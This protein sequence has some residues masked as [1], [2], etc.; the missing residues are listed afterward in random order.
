MVIYKQNPYICDMKRLLL[1]TGFLIGILLFFSDKRAEDRRADGYAA[2]ETV[3][4][5]KSQAADMQHRIVALGKDLQETQATA[6]RRAF[7]T[8]P[9]TFN[10]R[11]AQTV[12]KLLQAFRLRNEDVHYKTSENLSVCQTLHISTLFCRMASHVYALRKLVI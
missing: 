8:N 2:Q 9:S 11:T 1:F 7:Q 5:E 10:L 6:P 3:L 4:E 12:E